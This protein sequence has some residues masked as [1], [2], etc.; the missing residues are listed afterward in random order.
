[1]RRLPQSRL[2]IAS[3]RCDSLDMASIGIAILRTVVRGL[4]RVFDKAGP[5]V[6]VTS[7]L[8][9]VLPA[10]LYGPP[11]S[12]IRPPLLYFHGGGFLSC[13]IDTHDGHCRRLAA[14]S[15]LRVLAVSY[16]L[17]PEHPAP[18]Q[19]DDVIHA[20]QWVLDNADVLGGNAAK[21]IVG[22]DS[23]GAFLAMQCCVAFNRIDRLIIGQ[24]LF[25]PLIDMNPSAWQRAGWTGR[26]AVTLIGHALGPK[27][28][29]PLN[30]ADAAGFPPTLLIT[31]RALD[32]VYRQAAA[33]AR[34]L[35]ASGVSVEHLVLPRLLHGAMNLARL[36]QSAQQAAKSAGETLR[37]WT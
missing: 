34:T 3:R 27:R 37:R 33:F 30:P 8:I 20:C 17:A 25:Y 21:L 2:A 4:V 31:G 6:S 7:L 14:A 12:A 32:P 19:L 16:R 11:G 26:I 22:G 36:S 1:V 29:L 18:A 23:A 24:V 13:G 10:R 9:G 5:D 28:Y 35:R 15:G